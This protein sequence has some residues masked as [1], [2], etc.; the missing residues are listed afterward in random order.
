MKE[1][2]IQATVIATAIT[3]L[4][5]QALYPSAQAARLQHPEKPTYKYEKCYGVAKA[6]QNDCFTAGNSCAGAAKDDAQRDA[7]IYL[8]QGTCDKIVAGSLSPR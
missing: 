2:L 1:N 4:L 5:T 7:W 6:G 8:P 3:A